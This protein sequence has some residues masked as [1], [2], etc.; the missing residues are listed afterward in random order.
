M[1]APSMMKKMSSGGLQLLLT[2]GVWVLAQQA[3]GGFLRSPG[4]LDP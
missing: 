2:V 3:F 4:P 1:V